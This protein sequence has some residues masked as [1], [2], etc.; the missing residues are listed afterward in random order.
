MITC[1]AGAATSALE[2][3]NPVTRRLLGWRELHP[4]PSAAAI[5]AGTAAAIGAPAV[6]G[7][8]WWCC[9]CY[10]CPCCCWWSSTAAARIEPPPSAILVHTR[11]VGLS[12]HH[13]P[14]RLCSLTSDIRSHRLHRHCCRPS[15]RSYQMACTSLS[16]WPAG[17]GGHGLCVLQVKAIKICVGQGVG[18]RAC[19]SSTVQG[20][21]QEWCSRACGQGIPTLAHQNTHLTAALFRAQFW[22][23]H[24]AAAHLHVVTCVG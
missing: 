8:C 17:E 24:D 22:Q 13:A 11:C 7:C 12:A 6:G 3:R 14:R 18:G 19:V 23:Q 9:C 5:A 20:A 2:G 21:L 16:G 4:T 15:T 1:I 10:C